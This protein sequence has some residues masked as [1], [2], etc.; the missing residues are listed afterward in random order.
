MNPPIVA[1]A[2]LSQEAAYRLSMLSRWFK[3]LC[4]AFPVLLCFALLPVSFCP[5]HLNYY[6]WACIDSQVHVLTLQS[7]IWL[8]I[9]CYNVYTSMLLCIIWSYIRNIAVIYFIDL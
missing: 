5:S 8:K 3:I 4:L 2:R 7:K 9:F 1:D 6:F